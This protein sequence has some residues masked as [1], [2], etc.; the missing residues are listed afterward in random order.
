MLHIGGGRG[1]L[2]FKAQKPMVRP[3][4]G[5]MSDLIGLTKPVKPEP[6]PEPVEEDNGTAF[7][8]YDHLFNFYYDHYSMIELYRERQEDA[9]LKEIEAKRRE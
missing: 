4:R 9:M 7:L 5:A 3:G 8:D 1:I 2:A 6:E